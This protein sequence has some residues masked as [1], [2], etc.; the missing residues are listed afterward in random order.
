MSVQE[1]SATISDTNH[2]ADSTITSN[3]IANVSAP[4]TDPA[5][6][7]PASSSPSKHR[8]RRRKN[9]KKK[10][11]DTNGNDS[12]SPKST[13]PNKQLKPTT[14]LQ[15]NA[16][17]KPSKNKPWKTVNS[18]SSAAMKNIMHEQQHRQQPNY[19][20]TEFELD[21][22]E[23]LEQQMILEAIAASTKPQQP[24]HTDA[25]EVPQHDDDEHKEQ[26]M[27]AQKTEPTESNELESKPDSVDKTEQTMHDALVAASVQAEPAVDLTE[28]AKDNEH[29]DDEH[30]EQHMIAQKTEPT[31]SNELESKPDS[32]DKTQQTMHDALVAA[33][34]QAEPAVDLTEVA[35]GGNDDKQQQQK[36]VHDAVSDEMLAIHLQQQERA[37]LLRRQ[38]LSQMYDGKYAKVTS[39]SV[40]MPA[41]PK[42]ALQ[43]YY[44][45]ESMLNG[46]LTKEEYH[47]KLESL[48]HQQSS[49]QPTVEDKAASK[50]TAKRNGVSKHDPK[51]W[52]EKHLVRL[53]EYETGG[54]LDMEMNI[55]NQA[56]N[57]FRNQLDKKGYISYHNYALEPNQR[58]R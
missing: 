39:S 9:H 1:E 14:R 32:A 54:N 42:S 51:V 2:D 20:F 46:G 41:I 12:N 7:M 31:E 56:Y 6:S 17:S 38:K 3:S 43:F 26:H 23:L 45:D 36:K 50:P 37:E 57:S 49:D 24:P 53:N 11:T 48:Q 19:G 40:H 55:G 35:K 52:S 33:S 44:D 16:H 25:N 29:D 30:K 47:T 5:G 13:S 58:K 28:T 4:T 34:V 15:L 27:I 8:R 10:N 21:E 22:Q 18:S